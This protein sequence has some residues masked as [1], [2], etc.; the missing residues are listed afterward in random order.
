MRPGVCTGR[1]ADDQEQEADDQG[2][3][4]SRVAHPAG[5]RHAGVP[6]PG[7]PPA[8]PADLN[9]LDPA[10]WPRGARRAGGVLTLAGADVRDLA[11]EFGT[12]LFVLDE[13]DFRSRCRDFR[14]A[15][16]ESSAV[17]YAAKA[18][19][20]RGVLR[21]IAQ[22]GLGVDVCT[23]GELEVALQAGVAPAMITFHGSNKLTGELE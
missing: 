23:G 17:F 21:W 11:Q 6:P 20:S 9:A 5:P 13:E 2:I 8:P 14:Q 12:P 15:F 22:E 4:M 19:C 10:I 16:G 18:F 3:A 7:H 1:A